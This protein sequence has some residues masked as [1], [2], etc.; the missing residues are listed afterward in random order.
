MRF[1]Q[2]ITSIDQGQRE[3]HPL[4]LVADVIAD[5]MVRRL[6]AVRG[7]IQDAVPLAN[8]PDSAGATPWSRPDRMLEI[9]VDLLIRDGFVAFAV[10]FDHGLNYGGSRDAVEQA[11]GAAFAAVAKV[12][13]VE[14]VLGLPAPSAQ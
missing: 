11:L 4:C 12:D 5:G 9:V 1:T 10:V 2:L 8:Q 6:A 13:G 14:F 7:T 3:D